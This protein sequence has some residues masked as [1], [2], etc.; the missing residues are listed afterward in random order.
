M[1]IVYSIGMCPPFPEVKGVEFRHVPGFPSYAAGDDGTI[2]S[3]KVRGRATAVGPW[4][5]LRGSID[6]AGYPRIVLWLNGQQQHRHVHRLI[7]QAFAGEA[8]PGQECR[9]LDGNPRNNNLTNLCWGTHIQNSHDRIRHGTDNAGERSSTARL[10]A[11]QV[12]EIRSQKGK[13]TQCTL[14]EQFG[15]CMSA[16][17]S[18]QNRRTW[19]CLHTPHVTGR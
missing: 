3:C 7:L 14:A 9:H 5:K 16:I 6:R 2:W 4:R 13:Q 19:K 12:V 15:V 11:E 8:P 17:S 10:T 18:I 1:A